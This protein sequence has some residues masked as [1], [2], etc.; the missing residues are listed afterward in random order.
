MLLNGDS[1][2]WGTQMEERK[3]GEP[4]MAQYDDDGRLIALFFLVE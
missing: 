1:R 2:R 3:L 4:I